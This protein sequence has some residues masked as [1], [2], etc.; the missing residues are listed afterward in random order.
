MNPQAL[1]SV[2]LA[3][4]LNLS[5][6][7]ILSC[8]H[9]HP[10]LYVFSFLMLCHIYMSFYL[11]FFKKY[12]KRHPNQSQKI[13]ISHGLRLSENIK[14]CNS[15]TLEFFD[16]KLP[17]KPILVHLPQCP[18]L[19]FSDCNSLIIKIGEMDSLLED[20]LFNC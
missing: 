7:P 14:L 18:I 1:K 11:I 5:A 19:P 15:E 10:L 20:I 8:L 6:Y 17:V 16:P 4:V 9:K 12:F 2:T 13:N 3:V